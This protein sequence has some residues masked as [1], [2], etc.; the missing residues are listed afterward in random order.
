M[1]RVFES[2]MGFLAVAM[3]CMVVAV[4]TDQTALFIALG[5]FWM[6]VAVAVRAKNEAGPS[7]GED[8]EA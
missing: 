8:R 2:G 1:R 5:V 3:V 4:I 6:I 7:G